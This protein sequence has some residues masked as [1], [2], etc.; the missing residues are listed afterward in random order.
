LKIKVNREWYDICGA[1][2]VPWNGT[3]SLQFSAL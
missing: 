1:H 2:T 3:S